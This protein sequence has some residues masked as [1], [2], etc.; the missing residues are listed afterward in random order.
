MRRR[1]V[2]EAV[3]DRRCSAPPTARAV[4]PLP[5][6]ER[7]ARAPRTYRVPWADPARRVQESI[8]PAPDYDVVDPIYDA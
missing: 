4:P 5:R 7:P 2:P 1:V 8:D 3:A 6:D